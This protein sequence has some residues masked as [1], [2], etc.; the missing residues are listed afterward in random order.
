MHNQTI[1]SDART[2][3][4]LWQRYVYKPITVNI[5]KESKNGN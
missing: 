5:N 4:G 1:K 2:S 3:H